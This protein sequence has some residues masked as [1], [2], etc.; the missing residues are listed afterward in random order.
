MENTMETP[1]YEKEMR[2]SSSGEKDMTAPQP[3]ADTERSASYV[4]AVEYLI[5]A[6][7]N[8]PSTQVVTL[9]QSLFIVGNAVGPAFL[10]PFDIGGRK[11]VYVGSILVYAILNCGTAKALNLPMLI[12]FQFLSGAA[13]ST[14]LSNVAGTIVDL[15]GDADNAG[16]AMALFVLSANVG[17]S[18]GSPVSEWL[19]ENANPGLPWLFWLNAIIG[20][21]FAL[22]ICF[23]PETLPRIVIARAAK[24][25]HDINPEET[26]LAG[27]K[28]N[29]MKEFRF[30]TT[31]ALRIMVTE[32]IVAFLAI[33]N[34]FAY[35]LLFLYLDG[36][37]TVFVVNNGL[38]YIGADL[39]YLNF[40]VGVMVMFLFMPYQTY[41]YKKDRL[42]RG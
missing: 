1:T 33:Y 42:K 7:F 27:T 32:P 20:V 8:N 23:V 19:A 9:G 34:G 30:V 4:D 21:S 3:M 29:V 2:D 18:V 38:S 24:K 26:E 6:K 16:Q 15:F 37:F 25:A 10:G 39:T 5:Q 36:V 35:G 13:G 11:W 14:A 28:V 17:P 41:L 22:G 31:M 12:V 40:V